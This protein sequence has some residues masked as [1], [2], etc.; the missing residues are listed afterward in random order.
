MTLKAGG[1]TRVITC[2]I[3]S[4]IAGQLYKRICERIND[5]LEANAFYLSG[6]GEQVLL[7]SCDLLCLER[8]FVVRVAGAI[9]A[10]TG[11]P[12]KNIIIGC[13]H[14]HEG[15]Y[16]HALLFDVPRDDGYLKQL[17]GWLLEAAV[18]AVK[19]A[20]P[21][22]VGCGA[23]SAHI[24]YNRRVCWAD[25]SHTM[26]GDTSRA[27]FNG[28]E[29]PD[30]PSHAV[31]FAVDNNDTIIAVAHHNTCHA[32]CTESGSFA[33]ADFPGVA[34]DVI[35]KSLKKNVPVL[36]LQGASGDISPWDLMNR[37]PWDGE[38]RKQEIGRMLAAETLRIM[39]KTKVTERTVIR[40][41]QEGIRVA[42]KIPDASAMKKA[43]K[44]IKLGVEKTG[45]WD[46]VL[47][48]SR[49]KLYERYHKRPVETLPVH[50]V[51]IGDYA[52][53]TNPCELYC[54]FGLDIKR[55]SPAPITAVM[56]LTNGFS[57]YCPTICGIR[58]GGYS[59]EPIYWCRLEPYA[60]YEIV[61]VSARLLHRLWEKEKT[62]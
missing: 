6:K 11:I 50:V 21:A 46:Y 55:R 28:L 47:A 10:V 32:T 13:T 42:V 41:V 59:G 12:R 57:G 62:G 14:T 48:W 4:G 9:E 2:P 61:E 44:I 22:R 56:Q 29:G 31:V 17:H 24:G 53:A 23:G 26:Y 16:T 30:D 36:Y 45:Q 51:R 15:P 8:S 18:E 52:V 43:E 25:G 39:T 1:S 58:G 35:R 7:I 27:D 49:K 60:G 19:T 37:T 54:Q 5:D 34:R 3:G 20:R 33:S 38:Q 40:S